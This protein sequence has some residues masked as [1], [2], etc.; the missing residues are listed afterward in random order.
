MAYVPGYQYDLFVSYSHDD[1]FAFGREAGGG[2]VTDFHAGLEA[3]LKQILGARSAS[4]W[5]DKRRLSGEW[6]LDDKIRG[7]LSKTAAFLAIVSPLYLTSNYC[8]DEREWFLEQAGDGLKLGAM[9][10]A[11]RVVKTPGRRRG[12]PASVRGYVGVRAV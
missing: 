3:R 6:S 7:D 2:W 1:D 8:K 10:R 11:M 12:P 4:V 5:L 9:S